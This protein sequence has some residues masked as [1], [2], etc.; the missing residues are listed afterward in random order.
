MRS[1]IFFAGKYIEQ[2]RVQFIATF[3]RIIFD[4][5]IFQ[6]SQLRLYL[7]VLFTENFDTISFRKRIFFKK[8]RYVWIDDLLLIKHVFLYFG[9]I[10]IEKT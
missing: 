6:F 5:N 3:R 8:G 1:Q 7:I 10:L 4:E 9:C 2:N